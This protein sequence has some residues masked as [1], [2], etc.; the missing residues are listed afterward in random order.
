M[1]YKH[2]SELLCLNFCRPLQ[3]HTC[4]ALIAVSTPLSL[5]AWEEA[6][7]DH[8]DQAYA[9]YICQ[10]L[11]W[12]FRIAFQ[13]GSPLPNNETEMMPA[14]QV[15]MQTISHSV[16]NFRCRS[17]PKGE[18]RVHI[19]HIHCIPW[20]TRSWE[21]TSIDGNWPAGLLCQE[22]SCLNHN[23]INSGVDK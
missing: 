23:F 15:P 6:L 17:Q 9:Q 20:R 10:D 21:C 8:P 7:F 18:H 4:Q 1:L 5:P 3:E 22:S 11:R 19:C 2:T 13:H 12:G 16:E 14:N